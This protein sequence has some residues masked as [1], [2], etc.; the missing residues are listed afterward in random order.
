MLYIIFLGCILSAGPASFRGSSPSCQARSF[1]P[2]SE[3]G[4]SRLFGIVIVAWGIALLCPDRA[5]KKAPLE[6]YRRYRSD[7]SE[8]R[9][10]YSPAMPRSLHVLLGKPQKPL[11]VDRFHFVVLSVRDHNGKQSPI[12]V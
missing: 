12:L 9:T 10:L 1:T 4:A 7:V 3:V 11:F 2:G 6:K 8:G 5:W